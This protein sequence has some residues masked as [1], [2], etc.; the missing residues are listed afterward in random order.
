MLMVVE[1]CMALEIVPA[2]CMEDE[3]LESLPLGPSQLMIRVNMA[4]AI[5][6]LPHI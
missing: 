6:N 3:A 1:K 5:L 2:S 4:L